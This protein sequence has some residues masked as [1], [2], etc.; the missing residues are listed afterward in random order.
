MKVL[1]LRSYYEP[2]KAASQYLSRQLVEDI[3]TAGHE[4]EVLT[5]LPDRGVSK[6]CRRHYRRLW[7]ERQQ[8]GRVVIRRFWLPRERRMPLLRLARY[9][10]Q[11]L[12][13]FLLAL[14]SRAD[15]ILLTSTP[16]INGLL[17]AALSRT[18]RIPYLYLLQDLFPETLRDAGLA[19]PETV[20][21]ALG[22]W[23]ADQA[24]RHAARIAVL[25]ESFRAAVAAR[26]IPAE[27]LTVIPNWGDTESV[28]PV[29][30]SKNPLFDRFGLARSAF[31]VSYCG[32]IGR[33]TDAQTLLEIARELTRTTDVW[34]VIVGDG[35]ACSALDRTLAA[36]ALPRVM[37]VPFQPYA[38]IAAVSSLGDIGLVLA[39]GREL[40]S[41]PSKTWN[42]LAAAKPV[43]AAVEEDSALGRLLRE[44]QCGICVP[45][46]DSRALA[47][48]V[49]QLQ[50]R[51][52]DCA[53]MGR[54]GRRYV[55][56]EWTRRQA[57][58]QYIELLERVDRERSTL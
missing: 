18:K 21:Y 2:E 39:R 17:G 36:H 15:V 45:P 14:F 27:K 31:I 34:L 11:M 19:E 48:A 7:R 6:A 56:E 38:D 53:E 23:A 37:R 16:P 1:F 12:L 29:S 44:R 32:N 58:A 47:T 46:G 54:N 35:A 55:T 13:Q 42:I 22:S 24:Y 5:P 3:A 51:P 30:R 26:N 43:V 40:H 50:N 20:R 33:E 28:Q 9:L 57:T 10:L 41:I 49:R 8:G 4:V 52:A 25:S